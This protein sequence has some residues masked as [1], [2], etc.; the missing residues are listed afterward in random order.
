MELLHHPV[1]RM[2]ITAIWEQAPLMQRCIPPL[3]K[4]ALHYILIQLWSKTNKI[5]V[6]H[7]CK[8]EIHADKQKTPD[9]TGINLLMHLS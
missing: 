8:N 7:L 1:V 4:K 5:K 2:G 3:D 6:F 9:E